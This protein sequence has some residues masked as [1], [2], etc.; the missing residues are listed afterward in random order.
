MLKCAGVS[1]AHSDLPQLPLRLSNMAVIG[2]AQPQEGSWA[3]LRSLQY[4]RLES[5][6]LSRFLAHAIALFL[7]FSI[8][9]NKVH[10]VILALWVVALVG[11]LYHASRVDDGLRDVDRRAMTREEYNRHAISIAAVAGV[12]SMLWARATYEDSLFSWRI[13]RRQRAKDLLEKIDL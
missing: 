13:R 9:W 7:T 12:T 2:L 11:V 6:A 4:P 8:F 1:E 10:P 5:M 3:R